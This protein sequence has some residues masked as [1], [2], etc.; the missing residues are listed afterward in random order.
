MFVISTVRPAAMVDLLGSGDMT[1]K[2]PTIGVIE[3]F[4][5]DT[6]RFPV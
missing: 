2:H 1:G 6:G 4:I 5:E 3:Y